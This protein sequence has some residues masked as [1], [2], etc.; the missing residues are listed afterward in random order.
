MTRGTRLRAWPVLSLLLPLLAAA[1]GDGRGRP[2]VVIGS[3]AFTESVILGE[4]MTGVLQSEGIPATHRRELGGTR[5]LWNGL[6]T[7]DIMPMSSTGTICRDPARGPAADE[8][9]ESFR[10]MVSPSPRDLA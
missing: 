3:K 5:V 8:R 7:G 6:Q 4:I 9:H 2:A 10:D 1:Q